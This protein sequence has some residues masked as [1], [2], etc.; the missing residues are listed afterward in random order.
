MVKCLSFCSISCFFV[1]SV[2]LSLNNFE[3]SRVLTN[4]DLRILRP[5]VS[6]TVYFAYFC[7]FFSFFQQ[8][9]AKADNS[10]DK[11]VAQ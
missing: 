5:R 3:S 10:E 11:I 8:N 7:I 6:L 9:P 1:D 4:Q 2:V